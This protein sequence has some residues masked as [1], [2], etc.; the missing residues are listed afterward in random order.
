MP[1]YSNF[2]AYFSELGVFC[3]LWECGVSYNYGCGSLKK[4][5]DIISSTENMQ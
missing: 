1:K 5:A 4:N 2:N 3:L